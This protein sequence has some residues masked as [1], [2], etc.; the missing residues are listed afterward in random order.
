M[1]Q[2][3]DRELLRWIVALLVAAELVSE[4]AISGVLPESRR[5]NRVANGVRR[6]SCYR[7]RD[8]AARPTVSF[9]YPRSEPVW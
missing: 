4:L 3:P 8:R 5:A 9:A 7:I 1:E 6:P 2:P